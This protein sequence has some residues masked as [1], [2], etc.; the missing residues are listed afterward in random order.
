MTPELRWWV[1]AVTAAALLLVA[2][3][4]FPAPRSVT[5]AEPPAASSPTVPPGRDSTALPAVG[6][7]GVNDSTCRSEQPPL[8]LLHGTF[9][10]VRSTFAAMVPALQASGRCVYATPYGAGGTGPVRSSSE[11]VAGFVRDVLELTGAQQVDVV[12]YSQGGLVLR[13]AL[14][15][16]GLAP[17]V[18]TAVLIAPSFH[19]TTSPLIGQL[20]TG[21]CPAC[22]DQA[23][24]SSLLRKLNAGG[25]LDGD[26]RYAVVST[27]KDTVVTPVASQVPDGPA[28]RIRS[29]L[30]Q[31]RCPG[32][33]VDHA[34]LPADPGVIG[35]TV[36]ALDTRG[37][38]DPGAL[39][40]R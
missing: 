11:Q 36:D 31:D 33:T 12:G 25:D 7:P 40:C 17:L 13:T 2:G 29:L 8:I 28:D 21:L 10:T 38:P 3:C 20:P 35:W 30:M 37:R 32:S 1:A 9:S 5:A 19:G 39:T 27:S 22:D 6:V 26:V 14:R 15:D 18:G 23:A 24:G 4:S 16:E 34:R